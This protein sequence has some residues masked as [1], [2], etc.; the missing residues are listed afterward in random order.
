MGLRR[1]DRLG[2]EDFILQGAIDN[3]G[4]YF[5][6]EAREVKEPELGRDYCTGWEERGKEFLVGFW[7]RSRVAA[8]ERFWDRLGGEKADI[9]VRARVGRSWWTCET[10]WLEPGLPRE[11]ESGIKRGS[12]GG[13]V[14]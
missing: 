14:I 13:G 11:G 9:P 2:G 1:W 3:E 7:E 10:G 8:L 12:P 6:A 4:N 5:F